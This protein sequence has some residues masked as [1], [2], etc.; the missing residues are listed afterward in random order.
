M[1]L[2][3]PP[4]SRIEFWRTGSPPGKIFISEKKTITDPTFLARIRELLNSEVEE[5]SGFGGP[6]PDWPTFYIAIFSEGDFLPEVLELV[7]G[8]IIDGRES[9][10]VWLETSKSRELWDIL[11]KEIFGHVLWSPSASLQT[12]PQTPV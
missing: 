6:P 1:N 7:A 10:Y 12:Q 5:I 8:E 4:I 9:A 3:I 2:N 11:E